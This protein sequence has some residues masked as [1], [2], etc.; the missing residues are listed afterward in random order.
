MT[1]PRSNSDSPSPID[2]R[3]SVIPMSD[4]WAVVVAVLWLQLELLWMSHCSS[5]HSQTPFTCSL[6]LFLFFCSQAVLPSKH[7]CGIWCH[8][9]FKFPHKKGAPFTILLSSGNFHVSSRRAQGGKH[10]HKG[11]RGKNTR[12][13]LEPPPLATN[14]KE[15]KTKNTAICLHKP[16][17]GTLEK[18]I[19]AYS[20]KSQNNRSAQGDQIWSFLMK[21]KTTS[22]T[23]L[24]ITTTTHLS[25]ST[26]QTYIQT[27]NSQKQ[28]PDHSETRIHVLIARSRR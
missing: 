5:L 8:F 20:N 21:K 2:A 7:L 1:K 12:T 25:F 11:M 27:K 4:H 3:A 10:L 6:F 23:T 14:D 16:S 15:K 18:T 17:K 26:S 19:T 13:T 28:E 9:E 24:T 22:I